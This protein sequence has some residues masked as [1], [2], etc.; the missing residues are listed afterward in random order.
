MTSSLASSP[1][2]VPARTRHRPGPL[3]VPPLD[4]TGPLW[5]QIRRALAAPIVSGEWPPGTHIPTE[6]TLRRSFGIS[7]VTVGKAIQSLANEGLVCRRPR[8]GTIVAARALERPVFEIWDVPDLVARNGGTYGY[9]LLECRKLE[10]DPARR[11]MLGVSSRT[12]VLWMRCL[13]VYNSTPFQLEERLINIDAAPG[14]TCQPLDSQGPGR[15]LLAHVSWTDV[16]HKISA[17]EA[18][19]EIASQLKVDPRTAC[20]VIDRR[21]WNQGAPVTYARLWHPGAAHNLIGHFKPSH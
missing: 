19:E 8:I 15:W 6:T 9:Q 12:P 11:E 14:I 21:T 20:L 2:A 17:R 3:A 5:L 10:D 4:G 1:K 16:E 13:H 7:R 18:P